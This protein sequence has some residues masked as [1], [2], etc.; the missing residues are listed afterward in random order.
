LQQYRGADQQGAANDGKQ[1][2]A[3]VGFNLAA[4]LF[5]FTVA[6]FQLPARLF[7]AVQSLENQSGK[8]WQML[9][10]FTKVTGLGQVTKSREARGLAIAH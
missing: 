3:V 1:C 8:F 5:D 7:G 2:A 9:C 6:I 10:N 4:Q